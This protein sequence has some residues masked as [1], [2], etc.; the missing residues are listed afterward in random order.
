MSHVFHR[1]PATSLPIAAHG[2]GLYIVDSAG[3]RYL[4]ASGG[5]AVSC[6]GHSHPRV[7]EAIQ[8]QAAT[9]PFAYSAF[10]SSE[11]MEALADMLMIDAPPGIE[12]AF[13][14]GS[15][16]EA[17]EAAL[18]L[19][20]QYFI[21]IGQPMR[22]R[23]I[24]RRQSYH[25]NTLGALAIGGNEFR[26]RP[27]EP[28]LVA[29]R[30]IA[31][32]YAYRERRDD[33]TEEAYG[34]RIANELETVILDLGPETVAAFLAEPVAGATLGAAEPVPGYL[35]RIREI[36]NRY[37]VLLV[38]DEVLCGMGRTGSMYACN[39][40]GVA[41]DLIT[42]AK[43]LGAGYVPIGAVLAS[44]RVYDAVADGSG[45]LRHGHTYMGH[46][47][48]CAAALA[49]QRV[50]REE[51]LLENVQRQG[52]RLRAALEERLGNHRHVGD[53]R[54][55]GL[56][57]GIELVSDRASKAPFDPQHRLHHRILEQ[58]MQQGFISY[59]SG[60]CVD[61]QRGDH[62][63]LAPPFIVGEAQIDEIAE[64]VGA[65]IDGAIAG[66]P[67]EVQR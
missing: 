10:F 54:G 46:T 12:R 63:L 11:P 22:R 51:A 41:P 9:L 64:R 25:G 59:P 15:G 23:F 4:D 44:R 58:G 65:A 34:L 39:E 52:R 50:I 56:L 6:L 2:D 43:G 47:M 31:P 32:C 29:H 7:I 35:Q 53:I 42:V 19:A 3:K 57:V 36:C 55:R 49:V 61:G 60:G 45:V 33:E 13:F 67:R 30:H 38:F 17:I 66:L 18:K 40:E 28:M 16:S 20:R 48:A 26:R 27:Y 14:V 21:E 37:G 5:P 8:R 1:M 62:V 24:A